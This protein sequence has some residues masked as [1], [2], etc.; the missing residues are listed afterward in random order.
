MEAS[1]RQGGI[2]LLLAAEQEAQQIVNAA[3]SGKST[4]NHVCF[5]I[6]ICRS[7]SHLWELGYMKLDKHMH[8]RK[9]SCVD[10]I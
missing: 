7:L 1:R 8:L 6:D 4:L 2:K 5:A 10:F 9:E 3:R